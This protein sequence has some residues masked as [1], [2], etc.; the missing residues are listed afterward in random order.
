MEAQL[1]ERRK[2]FT[3]SQIAKELD[4]EVIGDGTLPLTGFARAT[5]AR[6]GDLTFAEN[7]TFFLKAEQSAASAILVDGPYASSSKALIRVA[8]ARV[9]F[10]RV[11]PLFF[12]ERVFAPGIH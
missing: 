3:T 11:L 5:A 6:A 10:A 2:M 8:N 12:P 7:E 9:A 1:L 4:G